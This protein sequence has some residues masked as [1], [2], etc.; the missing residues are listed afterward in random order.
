MSGPSDGCS[1]DWGASIWIVN[2]TRM[3][4]RGT[5]GAAK[6][7]GSKS[8]SEWVWTKRGDIVRRLVGCGSAERVLNRIKGGVGIAKTWDRGRG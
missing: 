4:E 3:L 5:V 8:G 7:G 1:N 2:G 6:L